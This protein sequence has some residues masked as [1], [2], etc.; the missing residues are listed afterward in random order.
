VLGHED[1]S[2][3]VKVETNTG[4]LESAKEGDTG[5]VGDKTWFTTTTTEG[6]EVEVPSVLETLEKISASDG[7]VVVEITVVGDAEHTS[8]ERRRKPT[9]DPNDGSRVGHPHFFEKSDGERWWW[10]HPRF[11]LSKNP[12]GN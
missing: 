11:L 2:A 8:G 12:P 6:E 9:H 5:F 4:G 3:D 7:S 1:V 10:T